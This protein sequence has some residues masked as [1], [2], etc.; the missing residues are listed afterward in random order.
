MGAKCASGVGLFIQHLE[1]LQDDWTVVLE[2][3]YD[4]LLGVVEVGLSFQAKGADTLSIVHSSS[5][6]LRRES[7]VVFLV[8]VQGD[9]DLV[10]ALVSGNTPESGS[11]VGF[12]TMLGVL[13]ELL[14]SLGEYDLVFLAVFEFDHQLSSLFLHELVWIGVFLGDGFSGQLCGS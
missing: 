3:L 10:L 8:V 5:L 11:S 9:H 13:S 1:N 2:D 14:G 12:F 7:T 6:N 4:L